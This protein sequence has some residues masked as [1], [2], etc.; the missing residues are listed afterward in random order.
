MSRGLSVPSLDYRV[1]VEG[2]SLVVGCQT[3]SKEDAIKIANFILDV[4]FGGALDKFYKTR[5]GDRKFLS[6]S[7]LSK[8]DSD[9]LGG[10]VVV[11]KLGILIHNLKDWEDVLKCYPELRG[12]L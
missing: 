2:S 4:D 1:S 9:S 5:N 8:K 6:T 12:K 10:L 11:N 3:I 7:G